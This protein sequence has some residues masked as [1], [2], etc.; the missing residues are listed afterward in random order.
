M[1]YD[2]RLNLSGTLSVNMLPTP[3]ILECQIEKH[4]LEKVSLFLLFD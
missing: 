1:P 4:L 3:C 2:D